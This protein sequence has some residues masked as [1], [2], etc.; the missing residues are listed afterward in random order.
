MELAD[1]EGDVEVLG[2]EVEGPAVGRVDVSGAGVVGAGV[3]AIGVRWKSMRGGRKIVSSSS[4][5]WG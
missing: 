5:R 1:C 4:A 3:C 2:S